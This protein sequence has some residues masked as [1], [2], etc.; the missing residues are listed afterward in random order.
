[1]W[2][3]KFTDSDRDEVIRLKLFNGKRITYDRSKDFEAYK[4]CDEKLEKGCPALSIFKSSTQNN[5]LVF[6]TK[7]PII[8]PYECSN[9][10]QILSSH[11]T[12]ALSGT[13]ST[14]RSSSVPTTDV[15]VEDIPQLRNWLRVLMEERLWPILNVTFPFLVDS[16][17]L[18][19]ESESRMR[20][21]DAFIVRYSSE[22]GSLSL[23]EHSD[24]SAISFTVSLGGEY[25]GGGTWFDD[26][27]K[28]VGKVISTPPGCCTAFAGPLRH[29]GYP[30]TSGT[31]I[32]LVLFC[33]VE[34]FDYGD[35]MKKYCEKGGREEEEIED[36]VKP[37][38]DRKGGYVVYRQT[39]ELANMLNKADI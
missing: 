32:I 27:E 10:L 39:V 33:Y 29:A 17:T 8:T 24:T 2:D 1:M 7:Q 19:S 23:P 37:S 18:T 13:W 11:I 31:R 12:T 21:H 25:E 20:L 36:E 28:D 3:Y 26:L 38:G 16:T 22:D 15:A 4:V 9:I 14:V 35:Y 30:I 6:T 5:E 34:G